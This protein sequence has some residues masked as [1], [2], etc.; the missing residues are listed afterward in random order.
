[1]WEIIQE[2]SFCGTSTSSAGWF[3]QM[4]F[5]ECKGECQTRGYDT[6]VYKDHTK[7]CKCYNECSRFASYG[8]TYPDCQGNVW[9]LVGKSL[10]AWICCKI[11][12]LRCMLANI[13]Y[14]QRWHFTWIYLPTFFNSVDQKLS[15]IVFK[16]PNCVD[17]SATLSIY[18]LIIRKHHQPLKTKLLN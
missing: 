2:C 3:N 1:M 4:S 14:F 6:I 9:Q 17:I 16:G 5:D 13:T 7:H 15:K 12:F 8:G 18:K 10:F 11:V